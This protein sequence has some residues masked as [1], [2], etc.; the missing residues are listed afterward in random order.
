ME[1]VIVLPASPKLT[2]FKL[3]KTTL[4]PVTVEAAEPAMPAMPP[5]P[6][7]ANMVIAFPSW[8]SVI[9]LPPAKVMVPAVMVAIV[10]AVLLLKTIALGAVDCE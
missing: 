6:A 8:E 1:A 3:E 7:L 10:P 4:P 5:A 9:L 2:L